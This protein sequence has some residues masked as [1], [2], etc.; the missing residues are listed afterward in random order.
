MVK[1]K[2]KTMSVLTNVTL[3][4]VIMRPILPSSQ[5]LLSPNEVADAI[6]TR[7]QMQDGNI[8]P[9]WTVCENLIQFLFFFFLFKAFIF[10]S[11]KVELYVWAGLSIIGQMNY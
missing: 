2:G 9:S 3:V 11:E 6:E 7:L 4:D 8:W 1:Q 10:S 5:H